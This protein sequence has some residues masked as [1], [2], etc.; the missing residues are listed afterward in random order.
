LPI[1]GD[2]SVNFWHDIISII[3]RW[4]NAF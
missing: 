4:K 3:Y 2:L 1:D